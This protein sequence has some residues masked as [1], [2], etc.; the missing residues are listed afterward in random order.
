MTTRERG[1]G[2]LSEG[3]AW[4][5]RGPRRLGDLKMNYTPMKSKDGCSKTPPPGVALKE[6]RL[7]GRLGLLRREQWR[8]GGHADPATSRPFDK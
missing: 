2:K 8:G 7:A 4:G 1:G 3:S 5:C 6:V